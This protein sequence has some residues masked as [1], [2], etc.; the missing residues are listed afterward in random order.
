M[1]TSID[2]FIPLNLCFYLN[3]FPQKKP[4]C[5]LTHTKAP[6]I[7]IK[8]DLRTTRPLVLLAS[9]QACPPKNLLPKNYPPN[10]YPPKSHPP[11]NYILYNRPPNNPS[12]RFTR[13]RASPSSKKPSYKQPSSEQPSSK[14][15][16]HP[17]TSF[18]NNL[19]NHTTFSKLIRIRST[20]C[21]PSQQRIFLSVFLSI[22]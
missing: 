18:S 16:H 10:N 20:L 1:S 3:H 9:G 11:N 8:S 6:G 2:F 12:A 22:T 21:L 15:P 17:T 5:Y 19:S 14:I 13:I 7:I 4:Y